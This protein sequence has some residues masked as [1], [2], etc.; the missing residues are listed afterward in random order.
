VLLVYRTGASPPDDSAVRAIVSGAIEGVAASEVAIVRS[1]TIVEQP[2]G[3][4]L[5][6]VGPFA[7]ARG[8]AGRLK[9]V[10]VLLA[11]LVIVLSGALLML[12]G[13]REEATS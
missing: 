7:V 1:E 13:R 11:G 5:V 9:L 2:G 10:L 12:I 6:A 8:S 4:E 3:V